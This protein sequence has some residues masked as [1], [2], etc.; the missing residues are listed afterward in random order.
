MAQKT[1]VTYV[2]DIT[3]EPADET[4][5]FGLDKKAYEIDLTGERAKQLR[6]ALAPFVEV[7]RRIPAARAVTADRPPA[8]VDRGQNRA[9]REWARSNGHN[10]AE[11]GRIPEE[12]QILFDAAHR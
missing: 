4:V 12:I 10:I 5:R 11:R 1:V 8:R 7:A 3:G 2:D 9:V 6:D